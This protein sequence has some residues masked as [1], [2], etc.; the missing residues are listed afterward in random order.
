[1]II[2]ISIFAFFSRAGFDLNS[3]NFVDKPNELM[4]VMDF[5]TNQ[6]KKGQATGQAKPTVGAGMHATIGQGERA[7]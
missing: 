3:S 5:Y 1:L 2:S 7:M 6:N 4:D